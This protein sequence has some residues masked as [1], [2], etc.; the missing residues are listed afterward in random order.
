MAKRFPSLSY[1]DFTFEGVGS[2]VEEAVVKALAS[3]TEY[4]LAAGTQDVGLAIYDL[5]TQV[6]VVAGVVSYRAILR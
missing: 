2:T 3:R 4:R 5:F 1:E 6:T